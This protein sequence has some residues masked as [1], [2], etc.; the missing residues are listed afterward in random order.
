[1][2]NKLIMVS[3]I[4]LLCGLAMLVYS[5]HPPQKNLDETVGSL[6]V[7][8]IPVAGSQQELLTACTLINQY[9][10]GLVLL[11]G[12]CTLAQQ[13]NVV[14]TLM[15]NCHPMPL[16]TQ[17]LEWGSGPTLHISDTL[18]IPHA[19]TVGAIQDDH[20]IYNLGQEIAREGKL[21]GVDI[22]WAPVVD[23]NTNPNNP[24][25]GDRSFGNDKNNVTRKARAYLAGLHAGGMIGCIKHFPG[26]GDTAVDSHYGLP[27]VNHSLERLNDIEFYPFKQLINDGVRCVMTAH[28]H[29]PVLDA[30][31]FYSATLSYAAN[32]G[33]LRNKFGFKGIIVS[34]ALRMK[35]LAN[36]FDLKTIIIEA[37]NAGN[38]ILMCP[39]PIDQAITILKQA[40]EDNLISKEELYHRAEKIEQLRKDCHLNAKKPID[41]SIIHKQIYTTQAINLK[42]QLFQESLTCLRDK[43]NLIPLNNQKTI[44]LVQIGG[45]DEQ[46]FMQQLHAFNNEWPIFQYNEKTTAQAQHFVKKLR[47]Y[48]TIII[49]LFDIDKHNH[50]TY[51]IDEPT[52]SFITTLAQDHAVILTIFGCPYCLKLFETIPTVIMAYEDDV[53]AQHA[54][55][56]CITGE[57]S[58]SGHLPI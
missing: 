45:T 55:A 28:I 2:N 21:L 19:M 1:M 40:V 37:F 29:I 23:I 17:D 6:F 57:K 4:G 32:A 13:A 18:P 11:D 41:P 25:I 30:R 15:A 24:V 9:H 12:Y 47:T 48:D 54:A 38:D 51:G 16:I 27:T 33:L 22:I 42:K 20:L 46:P 5:N 3:V 8:A 49:G 36:H 35:A 10:I 50:I 34:D 43:E 26:H 58:A 56:S 39:E 7:V 31:P 14:N 52:Q 44:A 53:D